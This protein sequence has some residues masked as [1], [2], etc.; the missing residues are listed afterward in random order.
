MYSYSRAPAAPAPADPIRSAQ[1]S[2]ASP[3]PSAIARTPH[4]RLAPGLPHFSGSPKLAPPL[5]REVCV[6]GGGRNTTRRRA[7]QKPDKFAPTFRVE[8]D[9]D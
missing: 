2:A 5:R 1:A 6:C 8:R 9:T 4:V 7:K 3:T